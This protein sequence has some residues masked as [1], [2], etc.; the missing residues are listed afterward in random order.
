MP[1]METTAV[2]D[3]QAAIRDVSDA[4][5]VKMDEVLPQPEGATSNVISLVGR[6]PSAEKT[7]VGGESK[8]MEAMRY[9]ALSGGKRLRPFLV[10]QS[11]CLFGVSR[12][13]LAAG[14]FGDRIHPYLFADP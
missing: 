10:V 9:S 6:N 2:T 5:S 3:L 13:G 7:A 1:N 8:V 14:R 12:E 11:A 4:L